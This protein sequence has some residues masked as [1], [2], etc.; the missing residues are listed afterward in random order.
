MEASESYDDG[1][2][3]LLAAEHCCFVITPYSHVISVLTVS[4]D[5]YS[6]RQTAMLI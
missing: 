3:E 4:K 1:T 6:K 5:S 2:R